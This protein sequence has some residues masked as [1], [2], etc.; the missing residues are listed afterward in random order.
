MDLMRAD[1]GG[2]ACT[3]ASIY[4]AA[5]LQLP[6]NVKGK[7]VTPM[8][9]GYILGMGSANERR[10]YYVTPSH[11]SSPY[12]EWSLEIYQHW[13]M[14]KH[15]TWFCEFKHTLNSLWPSDAIWHQTSE[16]ALVQVVVWSLSSTKPLP[17]PMLTAHTV[18]V[19][20]FGLLPERLW[21]WLDFVDS[22]HDY[23]KEIYR[24]DVCFVVRGPVCF[25]VTASMRP[26]GI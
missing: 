17:E 20:T 25:A 14:D 15:L 9:S 18:T 11:W 22:K 23:I 3:L 26:I 21:I 5:R 16:L 2:G 4:T 7:L 13:K 8:K 24:S 19:K 12:P 6:I 10:R 1:M